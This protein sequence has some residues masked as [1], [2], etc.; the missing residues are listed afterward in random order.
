MILNVRLCA[1]LRANIYSAIFMGQRLP[2]GGLREVAG[3]FLVALSEG[4]E[5]KRPFA[6]MP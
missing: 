6:R 2:G 1:L 5:N 3:C 4:C